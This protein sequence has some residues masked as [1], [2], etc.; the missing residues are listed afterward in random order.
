MMSA[1]SLQPRRSKLLGNVSLLGLLNVKLKL[2]LRSKQN[3]EINDSC[4]F[5][6]FIAVGG[7]ALCTKAV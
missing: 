3:V 7:P 2:K 6:I 1:V 4:L 5:T